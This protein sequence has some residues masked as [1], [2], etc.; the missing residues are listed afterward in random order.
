MAT[1]IG[2]ASLPLVLAVAVLVLL[3]EPTAATVGTAGCCSN[4]HKDCAPW[5]GTTPEACKNYDPTFVWLS[6]GAETRNCQ[7]R[8][9]GQTCTSTADCCGTLVCELTTWNVRQ[10]QPAV[11]VCNLGGGAATCNAISSCVYT[12]NKCVPKVEYSICGGS[13]PTTPTP[14][15]KTPTPAPQTPTPAPKTPTPAPNSSTCYGD[16]G[17]Q[18]SKAIGYTGV[19]P[20]LSGTGGVR[21]GTDDAIAF[22]VGGNYFAPLAAEI[23]GKAVVLGDFIIGAQGTNSIGKSF[24]GTSIEL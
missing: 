6:N 12:N 3:L 2:R 17:D 1:M 19:F 11:E 5:A 24:E 7:Q 4:N 15:P 20:V 9:G 10:C 14:A 21:R 22:L 8:W 23:E 18:V 16:L 13:P